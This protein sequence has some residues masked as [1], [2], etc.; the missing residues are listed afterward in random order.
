MLYSH[1]EKK[2]MTKEKQKR[3]QKEN[4]ETKL[5]NWPNCCNWVEMFELENLT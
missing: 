3:K 5:T 1:T 4:T 2:E